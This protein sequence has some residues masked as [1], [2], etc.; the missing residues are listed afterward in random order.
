MVREGRGAREYLLHRLYHTRALGLSYYVLVH[1]NLHM[2]QSKESI[3][4]RAHRAEQLSHSVDILAEW[5]VE[6]PR[7]NPTH[8]CKQIMVKPE[9]PWKLYLYFVVYL[10]I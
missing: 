7:G 4:V 6:G 5:S 10:S 1:V 3:Y 9:L 2:Y 8:F